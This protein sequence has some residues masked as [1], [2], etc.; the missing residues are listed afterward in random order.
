MVHRVEKHIIKKSHNMYKIIDDYAFKVKN[1]YNYA[2]YIVRQDY[3]E[4]SKARYEVVKLNEELEEKLEVPKILGKFSLEKTRK[5]G[6]SSLS[7]FSY[8]D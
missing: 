7:Y 3:I 5:F 2:N 6:K 8:K 4:Q 1:L